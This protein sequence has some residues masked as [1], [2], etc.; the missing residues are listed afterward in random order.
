MTH[1]YTPGD[2]ALLDGKE[3][4]KKC[5]I[6]KVDRSVIDF[7]RSKN[8]A[9]GIS[10]W[11][12]YCRREYARK[13]YCPVYLS[14]I[15]GLE[16]EIWRSIP[17]CPPV[18]LISNFG[19]IKSIRNREGGESL[20]K[21]MIDGHGYPVTHISIKR[22]KRTLFVHKA[23]AL[24]FVPNPE[25]KPQVNHI[26]GI[27]TD[28]TIENLEWVTAKENIRHAHRIGLSKA[29]NNKKAKPIGLFRDGKMVH[30]FDMMKKA[31]DFLGLKRHCFEY[32]VANNVPFED[33]EV[34]ILPK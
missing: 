26:N 6:C 27:K 4:V 24:A 9:S 28:F 7:D 5:R 18:Y 33:Y 11:C 3:V 10:N 34:K 25:N 13:A 12:K 16:G 30:S 21:T 22:R 2:K 8:H 20:L 29:P 14:K 19:R 31:A 32:R 17:G 23:V 15:E 1:H